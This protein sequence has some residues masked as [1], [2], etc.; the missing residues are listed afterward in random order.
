[1][2]YFDDEPTDCFGR[3]LRVGNTFIDSSSGIGLWKVK[4]VYKNRTMKCVGYYD[5]TKSSQIVSKYFTFGT[6]DSIVKILDTSDDP[7]SEMISRLP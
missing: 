1:M 2:K 6:S 3:M 5:I 7:I 4:H